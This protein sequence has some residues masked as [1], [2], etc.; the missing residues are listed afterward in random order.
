MAPPLD[1]NI[2]I[3]ENNG[4]AIKMAK[5][6]FSSNRARHVGIKH[7]II[8]ETV[9]GEVVDIEHVRYEEQH[10]DVLTEAS[11]RHDS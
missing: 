7:H 1:M 5:N 10:A 8:R 11:W 2:W 6:R 9:E 3:Y 4:R